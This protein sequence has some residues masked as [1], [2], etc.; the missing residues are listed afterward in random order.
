MPRELRVSV[1]QLLREL[2]QER[3]LSLLDVERLTGR[4]GHRIPR[5]RLSMLER[6]E[7]AATL[8]DVRSL[9]L[10]YG[11]DLE[12][13]LLEVLGSRGLVHAPDGVS[14]AELCERAKALASD[15]RVQDAAWL[16][17]EAARRCGA[18]D[19]AVAAFARLGASVAWQRAGADRL[20]LRRVEQALE[21]LDRGSDDRVRA[22]ARYGFLLSETG[23]PSRA[24]DAI[25]LARAGLEGRRNRAL[26]AFV[27]G[28]EAL[29]LHGCGRHGEARARAGEAARLWKILGHPANAARQLA[30]VAR[31][32]LGSGRNGKAAR[33]A[34]DGVALA[35]EAGVRDCRAW[36]RVVLA[37]ILAA[38][39]EDERA[40][41]V[42]RE[43]L[44]LLRPT[45]IDRWKA[46]ACA[47]LEQMA[48]RAGRRREAAAWKRRR[49]S[50]L[51]VVATG[52]EE[53][54]GRGRARRTEP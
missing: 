26:R 38:N 30:L 42:A 29:V 37:E 49:L 18:D 8:D 39:D 4:A 54:D 9:A 31:C 53:I 45:A 32:E 43:V 5:S 28:Y 13:L 40:A 34:L 16:F 51:S 17:D 50:F 22:L 48:A 2:R 41:E 12:D 23:N 35:D 14:P 21:L 47:V 6:G 33:I 11:L 3:G 19:R 1:G 7:V 25:S 46:R 24:L 27:A 15:G 10:A 52:N 44:D 20:A 36:C